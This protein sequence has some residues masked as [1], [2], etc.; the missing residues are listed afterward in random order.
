MKNNK[1]IYQQSNKKK[2][3]QSEFDRCDPTAKLK[4]IQILKSWPFAKYTDIHENPDQYGPDLIAYN[5][6]T[7][8]WEYFEVEMRKS[9]NLER[10]ENS[11][12]I[13]IRKGKYQYDKER[14][15]PKG[16]KYNHFI[17][18]KIYT[19]YYLFFDLNF[20]NL[21]TVK[22][23]NY[24]MSNETCFKLTDRDTFLNFYTCELF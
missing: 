20:D 12:Y 3:E 1:L 5:S 10:F 18:N 14:Y 13:P 9:Y 4:A 15:C 8:K 11:L 17:F 2:F 16:Y 24:K 21:K 7:N 6:S 22:V 23:N 19:Q